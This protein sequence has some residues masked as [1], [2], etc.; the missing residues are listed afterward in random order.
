M[1][2]SFFGAW[3]NYLRVYKKR[4]PGQRHSDQTQIAF[5]LSRRL[6]DA[7]ETARRK[8]GEDRSTF[9]RKAAVAKIRSEGIHVEEEWAMAPDRTRPQRQGVS[10]NATSRGTK[11]LKKAVA[12]VL[13]PDAK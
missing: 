12:S 13:K 1:R 10:S 8:S 5:A 9:I 2:N 6:S 11:V 3:I 7:I 4:V